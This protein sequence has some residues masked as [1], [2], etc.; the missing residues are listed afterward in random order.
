M[1]RRHNSRRR[2]FNPVSPLV[3]VDREL[4]TGSPSAQLVKLNELMGNAP[5]IS[6]ADAVQKYKDGL[7]EARNILRDAY[8]WKDKEGKP[9]SGDAL[10]ALVTGW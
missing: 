2:Q 1:Q 7:K 5:V 4:N 10:E 9:L 8:D 6:G 3:N